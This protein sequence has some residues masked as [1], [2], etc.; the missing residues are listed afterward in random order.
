MASIRKRSGRYH[1]QIRKNGYQTVTHTL[2]SLSLARKWEV[3]S[4]KWAA[5]VEADMERHLH[6]E[7]SEQT[8]L[9]SLLSRYQ[10]E[11]TPLHI[12]E[13]KLTS[14]SPD[15]VLRPIVNLLKEKAAWPAYDLF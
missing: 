9:L 7:V 11:V 1:V 4:G 5:G 15:E 3:G 10:D 2:S 12:G 14:A 8:T 6:I 13:T